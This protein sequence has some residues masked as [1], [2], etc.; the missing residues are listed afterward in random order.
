MQSITANRLQSYKIGYEY[1]MKFISTMNSRERVLCALAGK[2][3]DRVPFAESNFDPYIARQMA[4][5][6]HNLS[7]L[8]ITQLVSRDVL[9]FD[10]T[11][12]VFAEEQIGTD[13]QA[14]YTDPFLVDESA[15]EQI[16]W[17]D[18]LSAPFREAAKD[19]IKQRGEYATI[20]VT[21]LGISPTY[22]SMGFENFVTSLID[23]PFFVQE[24]LR[25]Y[26]EWLAPRFDYL[27][28]IGF[29]VIWTFDDIAYKAGL[30]ISPVMFRKLIIPLIK[31]LVKRIHSPWIFHSDGNVMQIVDDLLELGI[32]GLHPFEPVAMDILKV[33]QK[34]GDRLCVVGNIN[35]NT[36]TIGTAAEVEQEVQ[37]LL[38]NVAPMGGFM[39]TSSNS[40]PRFAKPE[41]VW[42]MIQAWQ[43]FSR[44]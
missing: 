42:A 18:P 41:N 40:I 5:S 32:N 30:F 15:L 7:E 9:P 17:P 8:E 24:I 23:R 21:R 4:N 26:T 19:C 6:N 33:K 25:C 38:E 16:K 22:L 36:L 27:Q 28:E 12:P 13:G 39:L 11:P 31:P 43:R 20:A 29:D 35:V 44:D 14:F 37:Y 1:R 2:K 10:A 3:P 34:Y